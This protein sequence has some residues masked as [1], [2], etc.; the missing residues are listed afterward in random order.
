[1]TRA[2]NDG[3]S[4]DRHALEPKSALKKFKVFILFGGKMTSYAYNNKPYVET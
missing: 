2:I 3:E 1:M 4:V